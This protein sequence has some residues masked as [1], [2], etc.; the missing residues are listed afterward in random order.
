ME[1]VGCHINKSS[2]IKARFLILQLF[3]SHFS[4][5]SARVFC[6]ENT[7]QKW[8]GW[9][10]WSSK[11]D[12]APVKTGCTLH[13]LCVRSCKRAST[14]LYSYPVVL[15]ETLIHPPEKPSSNQLLKYDYP[16]DFIV[17]VNYIELQVSHTLKWPLF[18]S[19][20]HCASVKRK[21]TKKD[22]LLEFS[23][24]FCH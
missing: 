9:Y 15:K 16:W 24:L 13:A 3:I 2:V 23:P 4:P 17:C 14:T 1:F 18:L 21:K 19:S 10:F 22:S 5:A 8:W 20:L 12:S 6:K 7:A 11:S